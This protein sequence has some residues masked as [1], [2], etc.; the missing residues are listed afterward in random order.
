MRESVIESFD[1]HSLE[2][3]EAGDL[4]GAA[5]VIHH[6]TPAS[7]ALLPLWVEDAVAKGARLISFN[8]P[9]YG[10]SSPRPGRSVADVAEDVTAIADDLGIETFATWGI[11]GG[12]PHALACAALLPKRVTAC[13]SLASIAP[14]GADGL[15]VMAGMGEDNVLE[16][17]AALA[18]PSEL[19]P[20]LTRMRGEMLEVEP[21]GLAQVLRSV[22]SDTD[23][24]AL[25]GE[26]GRLFYDWQK[27]ALRNGIE[28]WRDDDLAFVSPWGFDL[29]GIEV[30]VLLWQGAQ[31]RMVPFAHGRW[32][33]EHIPGVDARLHEEEGHLTLATTRM[34]ETL[35]WL[36]SH[37]R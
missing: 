34:A 14:W 12:G 29:S 3:T 27:E 25:T 22:L 6:G 1:G 37:N 19:V 7:R 2:V 10:E 11:S 15:D 8:R 16:F 30:P 20:L 35:D 21:E 23:A 33:A 28:G 36:L 18:G 4:E 26:L 32:L 5:V 17:G 24:A 9:G 13:A 31:D